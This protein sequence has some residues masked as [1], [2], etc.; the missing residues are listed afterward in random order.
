M[1]HREYASLYRVTYGSAV[2][3][4]ELIPFMIGAFPDGDR[5]F[6]KAR[7]TVAD[8]PTLEPPAAPPNF[9]QPREGGDRA[10]VPCDRLPSIDDAAATRVV[11][12]R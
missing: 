9:R 11:I 2:S 8:D 1:A 4:A 7:K 12:A 5:G 10:V 6:A 3:I